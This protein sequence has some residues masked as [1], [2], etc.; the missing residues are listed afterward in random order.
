MY[1]LF[2][3]YFIAL[4]VVTFIVDR[5]SSFVCREF[6]QFLFDCIVMLTSSPVNYD[7]GYCV[8]P[9]KVING[10]FF[11]SDIC[12]GSYHRLF[13]QWRRVW[14]GAKSKSSLVRWL[15]GG[16]KLLHPGEA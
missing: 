9:D 13:K 2:I 14:A 10:D 12:S 7:R 11:H 16:D 5:A 3:T 4:S 8:S 15:A 1:Y 6:S